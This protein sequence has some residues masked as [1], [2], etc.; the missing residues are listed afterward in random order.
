VDLLWRDIRSGKVQIKLDQGDRDLIN[1]IL[2]QDKRDIVLKVGVPQPAFQSADPRPRAA[3]P[4]PKARRAD[5][6]PAAAAAIAQ[7]GEPRKATNLPLNFQA[8]DI[9]SG[10]I[11]IK[12]L[13]AQNEQNKSI[14]ANMSKI[15]GVPDMEQVGAP[16]DAKQRLDDI[17]SFMGGPMGSR[18]HGGSK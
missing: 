10:K 2:E 1:D 15:V 7:P 18:L 4:R 6:T 9:V 17:Q 14:P 8:H 12:E 11:S 13:M 5:G 16:K 3:A